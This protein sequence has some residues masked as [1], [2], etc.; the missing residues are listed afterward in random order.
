MLALAQIQV[1]GEFV[2]NPI[3]CYLLSAKEQLKIQNYPMQ[4]KYSEIVIQ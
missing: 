2:A 1:L 3:K 4:R